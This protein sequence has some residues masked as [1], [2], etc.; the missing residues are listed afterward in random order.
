MAELVSWPADADALMRVRDRVR[1]GQLLAVPTESG[2]EAVAF[3]LDAAAVNRLAAL[4]GPEQPLAV[5]LRSAPE[6]FDWSPQTRGVALRLMKTFWP[7]PLVVI[8]SGSEDR[9]LVRQ[10][11]TD[12][13]ALVLRHQGVPLRFPERRDLA[14]LLVTLDG[15]LLV[16]RIPGAPMAPQAAA[17]APEIDVVLDA[18]LSPLLVPPTIVQADAQRFRVVDEGAVRP[19]D[20]EEAARCRVLFVCTGNTCRSPM[21]EALCERLLA[22]T[23]ACAIEEL[24]SRGYEI[25]SAGMAA[26]PGCEASPEAVVI[27][28]MRGGDLS[29]HRSQPLDVD[30]LART[31]H[32]FL[33]TGGHLRMLQSVRVEVGP[34]PQLL[35]PWGEDVPDPIGGP[36]SMY[37]E[38]AEQIWMSLQRRLPQI[39]EG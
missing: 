11:P 32:L 1:T 21:A 28:R 6:I 29:R 2:Y 3:A 24:T 9:G 22:D 15:P 37:H 27:A 7:G 5:L 16:A 33:M 19:T 39:L 35:S 4:A 38:C 30:L 12:V 36:E 25:A 20:L 18:G 14:A 13:R 34:P 10:L 17:E 26:S 23:L 8:A 31:D